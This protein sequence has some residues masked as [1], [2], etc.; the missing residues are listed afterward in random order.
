MKR[1]HINKVK[2][3]NTA[4]PY[5]GTEHWEHYKYMQKIPRKE[6]KQI[7]TKY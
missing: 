2:A 1:L 5:N 7:E 4:K 6:A 3:C